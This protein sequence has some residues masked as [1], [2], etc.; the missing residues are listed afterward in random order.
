MTSVE[1]T[2]TTRTI[3][4]NPR[5]RLLW[6]ATA[7]TVVALALAGGLWLVSTVQTCADGKLPWAVRSS[8]WSAGQS[9]AAR[10]EVSPGCRSGRRP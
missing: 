8:V 1:W 2:A 3:K 5:R 7:M 9:S 6:V 4:P 10:E